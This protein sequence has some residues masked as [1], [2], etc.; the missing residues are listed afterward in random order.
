MDAIQE[1][2]KIAGRNG[3]C[4]SEFESE[5]TEFAMTVEDTRKAC[6]R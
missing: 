3:I 2:R 6:R 5:L 1:I 4:D